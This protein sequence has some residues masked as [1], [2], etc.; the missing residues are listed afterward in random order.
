MA[1]DPE[2]IAHQEWLGFVQP[3]GLVAS[4]PAMLQAQAHVNRNIA[5]DHQRFLECLPSDPDAEPVISDFALFAQQVLGW[6]A[7]DL[8]GANGSRLPDSL[9][10]TLPV[11]NETLRPT[12]AV[13]EFDEARKNERW[14]M[15][16]KTLGRGTDF[17]EVGVTDGRRWQASPHARFERLL[18][19]TEVPIGLLFNEAE[20]RL[21]HGH[22]IATHCCG[23]CD[24]LQLQRLGVIHQRRWENGKRPHRLQGFTV[25]PHDAF[26]QVLPGLDGQAIIVSQVPRALGGPGELADG[27]RFPW[28]KFEPT[29]R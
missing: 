6:E 3:V 5:P 26:D 2:V 11:Y 27:L 16:V 25:H 15:L 23:G 19:E 18:R 8:V 14:I 28:P 12:Y 7:D 4:I 20:L 22:G 13:P 29:E 10:V 21:V 1:R 17:D 9:E 24:Q